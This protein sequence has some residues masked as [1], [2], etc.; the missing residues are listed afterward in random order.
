MSSSTL[1]AA[2]F[3]LSLGIR[4]CP[5]ARGVER[6]TDM[7]VSTLRGIVKAMGGEL[8]VRAVFLDGQVRINQFKDSGAAVG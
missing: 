6:R 4:L 3:Y 5:L 1:C 2:N 8:E 7:Y